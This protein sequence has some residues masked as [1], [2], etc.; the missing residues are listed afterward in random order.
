MPTLVIRGPDGTLVEKELVGRLTVGCDDD[1]DL[2]V[3]TGGVE[4]RHANF[5]ADGGEVVL[6]ELDGSAAKTLVDGEPL[7]RRR[8]L[9]PGVRVVIGDYE[10][11]VKPGE[12]QLRVRKV[13]AEP[14]PVRPF[15]FKPVLAVFAVALAGIVFAGLYRPFSAE[16]QVEPPV[17]A[18][19]VD[20]CADLEPKLRIVRGAPSQ[21][22]LDAADAVLTCEPLH[23]EANQAKRTIPKE[24]EGQAHLTRAKEFLE[25]GR[26]DQALDELEAIA[27]KTSCA[28][29]ALPL[30]TEVALRVA[31][32]AKKSCQTL[33]LI[34]I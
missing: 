32:A 16:P 30:T 23:E 10:V 26:D 6:E 33:S 27:P 19:G 29:L 2:V 3:R 34:H 8:R 5:F 31:A 24:L 7:R 11:Q 20:P 4:K 9:S 12:H 28:Q 1:N 25:L 13:P 22:A 14:T 18:A 17:P 15:P 21:A